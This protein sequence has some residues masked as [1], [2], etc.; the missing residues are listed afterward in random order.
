[1]NKD[2]KVACIRKY[3]ASGQ[4]FLLMTIALVM[5]IGMASLG[6]D[7]GE[8][9]TTRRLMQNAADAA[10]VSGANELALGG[11]SSAIADAAKDAASRNGFTNGS[12]RAGS[13]GAVTVS[14]HNPPTSGPYSANASAVEVDISQS[15]TSFFMRV[16]GYTTIPISTSAVA[17]T[18]GSGSCVYALNP[19]A[20]GAIT[21][22][23]TSAVSSACGLYDNSTSSTALTVSGGGTITAPVVGVVG[24]TNINGGGST[25]PSTG[26]VS[27]G[28][29]LNYIAAPT[30]SST[31]CSS[32]KTQNLSGS[33]SPGTFCGGISINSGSTVSFQPGLYIIDGGGLTING[34]ATV[35]GSGVTFYLTGDNKAASGPKNYAGVNINSTATVTLS[36]PCDSSAGAIPG[37]LFFQDRSITTGVGS[38]ING[39]ANS[40]FSGALYFPTTN[41]SYSGSTGANMFTLL[42]ADTLTFTGNSTVGNNFSC[43][44]NGSLIKDAALVQ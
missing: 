33:V 1:M 22:S 14:V 38:T 10:A 19:T 39:S 4:V 11:T 40:T 41:L 27:F 7:I 3:A 35:S 8:L 44:A 12:S 23:G 32:F 37:I 18:L 29:P 43:L 15:Q 13:A 5:I 36:S 28:D 34:G 6:V 30:V 2:N 25:P 31:A 24:G 20:P 17:Q 16:F 21:V 9:W 26:I 42:L